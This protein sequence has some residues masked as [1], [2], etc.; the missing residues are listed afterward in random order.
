MGLWLSESITGIIVA[1]NGMLS[2][3][4]LDNADNHTTIMKVNQGSPFVILIARLE[5]YWTVQGTVQEQTIT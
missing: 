4:A 3:N 2:T 1:V 5:R